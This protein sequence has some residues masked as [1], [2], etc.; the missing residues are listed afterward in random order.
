MSVSTYNISYVN[1]H[2]D[3]MDFITVFPTY[4]AHCFFVV[5]F[6]NLAF[7]NFDVVSWTKL[8]S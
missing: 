1:H 6:R 8:A 3:F 4:F 7:H 5:V 2:N